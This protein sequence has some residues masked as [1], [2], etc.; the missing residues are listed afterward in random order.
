MGTR[1]LVSVAVCK[2]PLQLT[3]HSLTD[4]LPF[5]D[6]EFDHVRMVKV[7]L[8]IPEHEVRSC[9]ILRYLRY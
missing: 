1:Q 3:V 2:A 4:P 9:S 6:E 7:S 8:G 5:E